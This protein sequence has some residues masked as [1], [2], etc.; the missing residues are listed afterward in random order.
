[1]AKNRKNQSAS[2][3]FGPALKVA[4]LCMVVAGS[5][6]G[7][8]WQKSEIDHLASIR[9]DREKRLAQINRDNQRLADQLAILHSPIM[10]DQRVRELRLGLGPAQP[11]QVTR[12]PDPV[13]PPP[14]GAGPV[15]A[16][17]TGEAAQP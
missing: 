4:F 9:V 5:A 1:M 2:I 16:R 6:I 8:V 10:L 12:M 13:A 7:Y 17:A 14:A 11:T 3:R 15:P